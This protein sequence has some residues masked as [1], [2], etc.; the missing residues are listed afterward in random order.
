MVSCLEC[1]CS[2]G[3]A[4]P[5]PFMP[6]SIIVI[7]RSRIGWCFFTVVS[8]FSGGFLDKWR[9]MTSIEF[10][11]RLIG[12]ALIGF[13]DVRRFGGYI[14]RVTGARL[15][16]GMGISIVLIQ[17]ARWSSEAGLS[18]VAEV[19]SDAYRKELFSSFGYI[20]AEE[21]LRQ[22]E[23]VKLETVQNKRLFHYLHQEVA[24]LK[25]MED[26]KVMDLGIL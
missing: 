20:S 23:V 9:V 7:L 25:V 24:K 2:G 1:V 22:L 14:P 4:H 26:V 11:A 19:I 15:V 5:C 10:V 21:T 16:V 18:Y 17:L 3:F 8:S 12:E 13:A 6:F